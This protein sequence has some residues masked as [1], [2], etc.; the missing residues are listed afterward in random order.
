MSINLSFVIEVKIST[1]VAIKTV[2]L[3]VFNQVFTYSPI[4]ARIT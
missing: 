3:V 1:G 4:L 2:T